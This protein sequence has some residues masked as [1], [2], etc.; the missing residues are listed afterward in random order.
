MVMLVMMA[1][2]HN[3]EDKDNGDNDFL[4]LKKDSDN[5]DLVKIPKEYVT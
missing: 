5:D 1:M 4:V 2:N 3:Y